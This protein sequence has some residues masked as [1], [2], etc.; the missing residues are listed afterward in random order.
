MLIKGIYGGGVS[1]HFLI[2]DLISDR[3]F[4][5]IWVEGLKNFSNPELCNKDKKF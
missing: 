2:L 4:T 1:L 5:L 3:R